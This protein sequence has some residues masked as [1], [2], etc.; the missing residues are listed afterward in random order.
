MIATKFIVFNA[1]LLEDRKK[2]NYL[3]NDLIMAQVKS[4]VVEW[5]ML[6]KRKYVPLNMASLFTIR[7]LLYPLTVVKTKIQV[8]TIQFN[9]KAI[10]VAFDH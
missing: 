6:N 10:K 2:E 8:R 3:S 5:H 7:S 4:S 1:Q 9:Q